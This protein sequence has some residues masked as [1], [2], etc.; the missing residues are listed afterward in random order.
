MKRG[1]WLAL[2]ALLIALICLWSRDAAQP[3]PVV[4]PKRVAVRKAQPRP[5]K[6][7]DSDR[8][9]SPSKPSAKPQA[10]RAKTRRQLCVQD[11]KGQAV[12]QLALVLYC[13][14][15]SAPLSGGSV[16]TDEEGCAE[17]SL[18]PDPEAL[19]CVR[20]RG[21]DHRP[22]GA[23]VIDPDLG[24]D[25]FLLASPA[26]VH[27][28]L[29]DGSDQA[30][31]DAQLWFEAEDRDR[32]SAPPFAK[33][34]IHSD[35][36]GA[37]RFVAAR[38][39]PCDPCVR[40]EEDCALQRRV[41]ELDAP[42]AGKIW[43]RHPE[44]G[45]KAVPMPEQWG[46]L[47]DLVMDGRPARIHGRLSGQGRRSAKLMLRHQRHRQDRQVTKSDEDGGF[48]FDG[49]G[50]G[51]YE[52]SV[53]VDGQPVLRSAPVRRGEMLELSLPDRGE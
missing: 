5:A 7:A 45:L 41:D 21:S 35:A 51:D 33:M 12:T 36:Q 39:L 34:R 17:I 47:D 43:I 30:V 22:A 18:C 11:D 24:S 8:V 53:F 2:G 40:D 6:E 15:T 48:D 44:H 52:L 42:V 27:G 29:I 25:R 4:A 23:W 13:S 37:F 20:P 28:R 50:P 9:P 16:I 3:R 14:D 31:I 49:L 26:I 10:P 46:A 38:P 1:L 32:W 19:T